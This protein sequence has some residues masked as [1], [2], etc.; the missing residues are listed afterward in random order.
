MLNHFCVATVF[1]WWSIFY[2]YFEKNKKYGIIYLWC[3]F[4]VDLS[5]RKTIL[6]IR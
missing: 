3:S 4:L 6:K 2:K 1:R 5:I